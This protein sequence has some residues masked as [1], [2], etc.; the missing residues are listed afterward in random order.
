M[1]RHYLRII[2]FFVIIILVVV[3]FF[4]LAK[5]SDKKTVQQNLLEDASI[6]ETIE[7]KEPV[8]RNENEENVEDR[9][10]AIESEEIIMPTYDPV[11]EAS[12][13]AQNREMPFSGL[14]GLGLEFM[15]EAEKESFSIPP[16]QEVQI[17]T[18]DPEGNISSYKIIRQPE[19]IVYPN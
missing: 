5:L 12:L 6:E 3:V 13:E 7:S 8:E 16:K 17:L 14:E 2:I 11:R 9:G 15:N 1:R 4:V 10:E 18:R 19:N